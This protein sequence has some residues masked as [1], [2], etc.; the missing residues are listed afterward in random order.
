MTKYYP[1]ENTNDYLAMMVD[2]LEIIARKN[3]Y[4]HLA[5]L[6]ALA[7]DEANRIAKGTAPSHVEGRHVATGEIT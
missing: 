3:G 1:G 7:A 4:A 6:L 2:Q 5:H